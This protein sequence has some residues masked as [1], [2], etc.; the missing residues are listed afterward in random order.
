MWKVNLGEPKRISGCLSSSL[1]SV[2]YKRI[3]CIPREARYPHYEHYVAS[4]HAGR[5]SSSSILTPE[6]NDK[7]PGFLNPRSY[8]VHA[9]CASYSSACF[10]LTESTLQPACFF[11]Y[12]CRVEIHIIRKLPLSCL[13]LADPFPASWMRQI[14]AACSASKQASKLIYPVKHSQTILSPADGDIP[15]TSR[16]VPFVKRLERS[17]TFIKEIKLFFQRPY[18]LKSAQRFQL[19]L[20]HGQKHSPTTCI[21]LFSGHQVF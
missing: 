14:L 16:S 2:T 15:C 3:G 11:S 7:C 10:R 9:G 19:L 8:N 6:S 1:G 21:Q 18:C 5:T 20:A 12:S 13:A 4:R 17:W